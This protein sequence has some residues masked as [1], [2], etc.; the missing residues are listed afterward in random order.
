MAK[1]SEHGTQGAILEYLRLRGIFAYR[2]NTG[3]IKTENRFIKFGTPGSPDIICVFAGRFIGLEVK[4]KSGKQNDNQ[5]AFQKEL[6]ER[7]G[8]IYFVVR[9]VEEAQEAIEDAISRLGRNPQ[10]P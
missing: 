7:G 4:T 9:S 8:G 2:N 6:V 1:E 10:R 5:K 3:A